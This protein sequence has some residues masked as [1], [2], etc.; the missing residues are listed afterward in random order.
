MAT[1]SRIV[2]LFICLLVLNTARTEDTEYVQAWT[3]AAAE[4]LV[5]S[6]RVMYEEK[7]IAG[8]L[9]QPDV[10]AIIATYAE[11]AAQCLTTAVLSVSEQEDVP[12]QSLVREESLGYINLALLDN[13]E[14]QRVAE[15]CTLTALENAGISPNS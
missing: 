15:V 11:D 1:N 7:L 2:V 14:F 6:A 12:F 3:N 10:D 5:E 9:A 4:I 8:G 13:H